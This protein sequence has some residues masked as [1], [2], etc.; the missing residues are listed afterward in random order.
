MLVEYK[1]FI[2]N[3]VLDVLAKEKAS[4]RVL[5]HLCEIE[6]AY[7]F[8]VD[9]RLESYILLH[10]VNT[11][12][13]NKK[14]SSSLLYR[15]AET[16]KNNVKIKRDIEYINS[17][18]KDKLLNYVFVKGAFFITYIYDI[19]IRETKDI[20]LVIEAQDLD[21]VSYLLKSRNFVQRINTRDGYRDA[22]RLEIQFA[23]MNNRE[24]IPFCKAYSDEL[25]W[26]D[27]NLYD[28]CKM[29]KNAVQLHTFSITENIIYHCLEL[30]KELKS[31][32]YV[33]TEKNI[34]LYKFC[35]LYLLINKYL[36]VIEVKK[37]YDICFNKGVVKEVYF[38]FYLMSRLFIC[39]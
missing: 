26:L 22:N 8:A 28:D 15:Y 13:F 19:G 24:V 39:F 38:I 16:V 3:I 32:L 1:D 29:E 14:I 17:I 27:I 36:V 33:A 11:L 4:E 35:D 31:Y 2:W 25:I 21:K 23:L 12:C 20:D 34:G 5:K 37:I 10:Q 30:Y 9:N 18:F 6:E 7:D